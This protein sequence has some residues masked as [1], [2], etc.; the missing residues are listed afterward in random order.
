MSCRTIV[1]PGFKTFNELAISLLTV[2]ALWSPSMNIMS[3]VSVCVAKYPSLVVLTILS[4]SRSPA[5]ST[6]A[7]FWHFIR[8]QLYL[9]W[10][11]ISRYDL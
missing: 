9:Y 8:F 6:P 4:S 11:P 5:G 10:M 1:P 2:G 7:M 3:N